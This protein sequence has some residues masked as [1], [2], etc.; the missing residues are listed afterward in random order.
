MAIF[1]EKQIRRRIA[2]QIRA[3]HFEYI[4]NTEQ[5]PFYSCHPRSDS[6][7]GISAIDESEKLMRNFL[8]DNSSL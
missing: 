4:I 6:S 7:S 2:E 5:K 1:L 8:L 3:L